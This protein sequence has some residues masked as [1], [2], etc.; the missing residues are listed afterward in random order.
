MSVTLTAPTTNFTAKP[1]F[2]VKRPTYKNPPEK[3]VD[4]ATFMAVI[5]ESEKGDLINGV[6]KLEARVSIEHEEKFGFLFT[7]L[8]GYVSKNDMGQVLGS[9]TLVK[10]NDRNG[11]EPDILFVSKD[12]LDIIKPHDIIEGPDLVVEIIS[13]SSRRDDRVAKFQGYEQVGVQDYWIIDPRYGLVEFYRMT[14]GRLSQVDPDDG[15]FR[16]EAVPGFWLNVGWLFADEP[17]STF[18]ALQEIIE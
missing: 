7:L 10:I 1:P 6:M 12:R 17:V 16:S 18:S 13:P 11:Y 14:D 8:V 2:M 5:K 3:V 9:R 15:I 4:Y